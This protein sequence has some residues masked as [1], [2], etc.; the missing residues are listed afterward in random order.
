MSE[1]TSA[2]L[3]LT[4]RT[5][6]ALEARLLKQA[7]ALHDV[8]ID[9]PSWEPFVTTAIAFFLAKQCREQEAVQSVTMADVQRRF[10]IASG[11]GGG[12]AGGG[13]GAAH[14]SGRPRE[15]SGGQ[16]ARPP[17]TARKADGETDRTAD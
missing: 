10:G 11:G 13:G 1:K 5:E 17:R 16:R 15:R 4:K 12:A 6:R 2:W 7:Q 3:T 9:S 8:P 14:T